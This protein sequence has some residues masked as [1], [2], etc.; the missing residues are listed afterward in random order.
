MKM[1]LQPRNDI[2]SASP[3]FREEFRG[4][5]VVLFLEVSAALGNEDLGLTIVEVERKL[6][7]LDDNA[8]SGVE[9]VADGLTLVEASVWNILMNLTVDVVSQSDEH[10]TS[11]ESVESVIDPLLL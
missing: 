2:N 3:S 6:A 8:V 7:A 9:D 11:G 10:V 1:L 5:G 4:G